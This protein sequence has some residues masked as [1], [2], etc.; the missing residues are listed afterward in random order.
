MVGSKI[1]DRARSRA[2][3]RARSRARA[4]ARAGAGARARARA[5]AR[6][7]LRAVVQCNTSSEATVGMPMPEFWRLLGLHGYG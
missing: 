6:V 2:R 5:R 7:T 3:A 1:R 4:R